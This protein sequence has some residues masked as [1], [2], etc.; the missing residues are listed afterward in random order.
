[1]NEFIPCKLVYP[2]LIG[3]CEVR[4]TKTG[5]PEELVHGHIASS[6]LMK[7]IYGYSKWKNTNLGPE[8]S[9]CN[10][11]WRIILM[12]TILQAL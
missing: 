9:I 1:M 2:H 7:Y 11:N 8:F 6:T 5:L 3:Q 4:T 10:E 12:L